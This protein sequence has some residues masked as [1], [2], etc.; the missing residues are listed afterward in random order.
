MCH[1]IAIIVIILFSYIDTLLSLLRVVTGSCR[2][3]VT[4]EEMGKAA[5]H[6][7]CWLLLPSIIPV[8]LP[9]TVSAIE[10]HCRCYIVLALGYRQIRREKPAEPG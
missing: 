6:A 8:F 2:G 5:M 4:G 10:L 3:G 7:I 1:D 9:F